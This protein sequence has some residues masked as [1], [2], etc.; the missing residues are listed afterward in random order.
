[1]ILQLVADDG[2]T[3]DEVAGLLGITREDAVRGYVGA[4]HQ[5]N[6]AIRF[7]HR[8]KYWVPTR[9]RVNSTRPSA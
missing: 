1:M 9:Y 8:D 4:R 2:R 7:Q 3:Y 5:L 6:D